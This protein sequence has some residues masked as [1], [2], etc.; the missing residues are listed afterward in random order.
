[1]NL[2]FLKYSLLLVL[3]T[4]NNILFAQQ[5]LIHNA[6]FEDTDDISKPTQLAEVE[7]LEVWIDDILDLQEGTCDGIPVSRSNVHSPDWYFN[8]G[9][10]IYMQEDNGNGMKPING[11]TGSGYIGMASCELI[12]QQFFDNNQFIEGKEYTLSMYIRIPATSNQPFPVGGAAFSTY[13]SAL[14]K[15]SVNQDKINYSTGANNECNFCKEEFCDKRILD[16]QPVEIMSL[17][18]NKTNFPP[19]QW[20]KVS[21]TFSAPVPASPLPKNDWITIELQ[22]TSAECALYVLIDDVSLE[23]GCEVE[24]SRTDG[25]MQPFVTG[26]HCGYLEGVQPIINKTSVI[27]FSN[28]ANATK[29]TIVVKGLTGQI[30][31][32]TKTVTCA[33]GINGGIYWDGK[34]NN[35]AGVAS[36]FYILT[37]TLENDCGTEN[38]NYQIEVVEAYNPNYCN[39]AM[40][41]DFTCNEYDL[42]TPQPCCNEQPDIYINNL[43]IGNPESTGSLQYIAVNNI[44]IGPD[45]TIE[46]DAVVLFQAGNEIIGDP[47]QEAE[48]GSDVTAEIIPCPAMRL[49]N[50]YVT[51][52]TTDNLFPAIPEATF[53]ADTTNPSSS[54]KQNIQILPNPSES[55]IFSVSGLPFSLHSSIAVY[56]VLGEKIY[57]KRINA[58]PEKIGAG[59]QIDSSPNEQFNQSAI[60][61][62]N[63][64]H[65]IYFVKI[66]NGGEISVQKIV[67]Q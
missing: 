31:H 44:Y 6:G 32:Y 28:L 23:C 24:C 3:F 49:A 57:E 22:R 16:Q 66:T 53:K 46:N 39:G 11:H 61:I 45:V 13:G 4:A 62:S 19:S 29:A 1:M 27:K 7:F 47:F 35:N 17:E 26:V 21:A 8:V 20:H 67:Y 59:L 48:I 9:G 37:L 54:Q 34:N 42:V 55:G 14:L 36:A 50:P 25:C 18:V 12:Q 15:V 51:D 64:P 63:H 30:V 2:Q 38:F 52:E 58:N 40:V 43:T 5:D 60:D 33:N 56:T 41:S 10:N 65:G